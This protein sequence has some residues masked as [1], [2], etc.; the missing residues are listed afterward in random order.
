M[1]PQALVSLLFAVVVVIVVV[2]VVPAAVSSQSLLMVISFVTIAEVSV[3]VIGVVP[4][5]LPN[6]CKPCIEKNRPAAH[7]R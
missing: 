5:L 7:L 6:E 4:H 2:I 3:V 1:V